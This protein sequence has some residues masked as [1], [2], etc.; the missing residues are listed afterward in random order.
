MLKKFKLLNNGE[1]LPYSVVLE[2]K[3]SEITYVSDLNK[4]GYDIEDN[5][6][7]EDD[8]SEYEMDSEIDEKDELE[9]NKDDY[10]EKAINSVGG[11]MVFI[12]RNRM[13]WKGEDAD[14]IS[15]N[16]DE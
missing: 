5:S 4:L 15:K 8:E 13:I 6:E 16:D 11:S 1:Y 14:A 12:E 3:L 9:E 2:K 10:E 7:E